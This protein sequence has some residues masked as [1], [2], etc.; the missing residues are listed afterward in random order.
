MRWAVG[1]DDKEMAMMT[2][3]RAVVAI[4]C[5]WACAAMGAESTPTP[6]AA[7]SGA[8]PGD[9]A[10]TCDQIY[11]QGM[12][13]TRRMQQ[14][15]EQK[16]AQMRAQSN[17]TAALGTSA[18]LTGGATALAA[19][20]AAENQANQTIGMLGSTP[21]PNPRMDHL[22]KLFAEKHCKMP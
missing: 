17:T 5:L 9:D 1:G 10:L 4:C 18:M 7:S 3:R 2:M 21:P 13:E 19:Q 15:R 22:K 12:A 6:T 14:E 20:A 11:A 8:M 16:A